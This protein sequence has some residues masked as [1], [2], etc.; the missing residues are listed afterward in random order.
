MYN[1]AVEIANKYL[2]EDSNSG[3]DARIEQ[4]KA[5]KEQITKQYNTQ[6]EQITKQY[7][8]RIEQ[9]NNQIDQLGGSV[10][11]EK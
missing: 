5:Q 4:L 7:N 2:G 3:N 1:R 6:K 10:D 9:I 8:Q 11:S